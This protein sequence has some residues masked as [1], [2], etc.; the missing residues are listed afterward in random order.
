MYR[1]VPLLLRGAPL[2]A[3]PHLVVL[4]V[5]AIGGWVICGG[6]VALVVGQELVAVP[7]LGAGG[8]V[9]WDMG[10]PPVPIGPLRG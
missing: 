5:M 2:L 7:C 8:V 6:T 9:G 4:C 10:Y 1:G 3:G